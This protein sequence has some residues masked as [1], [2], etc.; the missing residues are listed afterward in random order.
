MN[1]EGCGVDVPPTFVKLIERNQ[2]PNCDGPIMSENT[3]S[4][5]NELADALRAMPNDARGLAGWLMTHYHIQ[6]KSE[7][8]EP[9]TEFHNGKK[10]PS[11][12]KFAEK[13]EKNGVKFLS[14]HKSMVNDIYNNIDQE[15]DSD[16]PTED[17]GMTPEEEAKFKKAAGA[18]LGGLPGRANK[19]GKKAET[20]FEGVDM[21]N[22][23]NDG[24]PV[25]LPPP[26]TRADAEGQRALLERIRNQKSFDDF[27]SLNGNSPIK[28]SES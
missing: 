28:R 8:A 22:V 14:S 25:N 6:K 10:A 27:S 13:A 20:T 19:S 24:L 18:T 9:V 11:K 21:S 12:S 16:Y 3:V 26:T 15:E 4:L 17:S 2:C 5:I 1:C 23:I 7:N